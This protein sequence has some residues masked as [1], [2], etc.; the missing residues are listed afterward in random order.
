M[1]MNP[2]IASLLKPE[3]YPHPTEAIRLRETHSAWV[4][5]TGPYA[6]KLRKPVNFGFLDFSSPA[7]RRW[8]A[9]EELRL[10]RRLSPDLYIDL[11]LMQGSELAVRMHQFNE[12][13]LLPAA[14]ERGD[15]SRN[16]V[17]ALAEE[18]ATFHSKA[19]VAKEEDGVGTAPVILEP[20][21]EN[22]KAL[23]GVEEL[24]ASLESLAA[25]LEQTFAELQPFFAERL[26]SGCIRE[27]HGDLHLGNMHLEGDRIRVFD[28]KETEE[29]RNRYLEHAIGCSQA[30]TQALLITHGLS[31]S[32]KSWLC[33]RIAGELPA[34]QLRSDV[35]RKRLFGLWGEPRQKSVEGK[36]YSRQISAMLFEHTLPCQAEALLRGG[37]TALVDACF[38]RRSERQR[39]AA[40]AKQQGVPL[41]ILKLETPLQLI[42]ARIETRQ[43]QGDDPS[44]ATW[45]VV[46]QQRQ[47]CEPISAMERSEAAVLE[48]QEP[49]D[50]AAALERIRAMIRRLA[51]QS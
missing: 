30:Q 10:N 32:G 12:E 38:L 22:L 45:E 43:R 39:M 51:Q 4:L 33:R 14:L 34:L 3:A 40:L 35:E 36:L 41:V 28:C 47:W 24:R 8:F 21:L 44:D 7:K 31:G 13:K 5:L 23:A 1:V 20:V 15:L 29:E 27:C 48:L 17:Q 6:Y 9:S 26:A 37:F 18:L 25:W 50:A 11:V 49:I 42:K 19:A 46:Q 2:L 16:A